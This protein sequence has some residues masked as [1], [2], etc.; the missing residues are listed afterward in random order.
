M[1]IYTEAIKTGILQILITQSYENC[2]ARYNQARSIFNHIYKSILSTHIHTVLTY[3][4]Q[5]ELPIQCCG[6]NICYSV[7]NYKLHLVLFSPFL[8]SLYTTTQ[9]LLQIRNSHITSKSGLAICEP[10]LWC[11]QLLSFKFPLKCDDQVIAELPRA[12][13]SKKTD[14]IQHQLFKL[15]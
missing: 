11:C 2:V 13:E 12:P 14:T 5:G 1:P 7:Y 3:S 9:I 8:V 10:F 4:S 15:F 6:L